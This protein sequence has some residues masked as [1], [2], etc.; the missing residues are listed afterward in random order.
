MSYGGKRLQTSLV[1]VLVRDVPFG[2]TPEYESLGLPPVGRERRAWPGS[3][4]R[5]LTCTHT[6]THIDTRSRARV[7]YTYTQTVSSAPPPPGGRG[8][9]LFKEQTVLLQTLAL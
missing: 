6:Y 2:N 9:F 8:L 4:T 1:T 5:T 7:H 3:R